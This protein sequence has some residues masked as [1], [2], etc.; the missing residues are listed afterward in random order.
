[1]KGHGTW[2]DI[3]HGGTQVS[4]GHR[5][6]R[7]TGHEGT[8]DMEGHGGT[9]DTRTHGLR[10]LDAAHGQKERGRKGSLEALTQRLWTQEEAWTQ[11][12]GRTATQET[13]S[14]GQGDY[15]R[16]KPAHWTHEQTRGRQ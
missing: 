13:W 7:D 14:Q 12:S 4:D 5:T 1:M 2:R 11:G 15:G 8:Q 3:G 10:D 9:K 16:W 6:R